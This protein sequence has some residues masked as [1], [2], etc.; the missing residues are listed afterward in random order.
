MEYALITGAASGMGRIYA[1]RLKRMGY[2]LAL[3][4]ID[5]DGLATLAQELS[6]DAGTDVI[7]I[8]Q[9]LTEGDAAGKIAGRLERSGA[10]V[11][12]LV[13][14]AGMIFTTPIASTPARSLAKMTALHITAPLLLCREFVPGMVERGGGRIL[15]VSSICAW[16]HWPAIGM[17]GNT[18]A[19]IRDFS[20]SLRLECRGTGVSVTTA[21]FGAVDTPLFGFSP[22]TRRTLRRL[23]LMIT[24]EKAVDRALHA[25]FKGKKKAAPGLLNR[26]AVPV[27]AILPD[28]IISPLYRKFGKYLNPRG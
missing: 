12:V 8:V 9:D 13:N 15:N 14:N 1:A 20:R 16:M 6:V 17:Y 11:A 19:F 25:L 4:D 18:K 5:A 7:C 28:C 26:L 22:S 3:V 27:V 10:Q 24:P 21:I 2:A 23:G